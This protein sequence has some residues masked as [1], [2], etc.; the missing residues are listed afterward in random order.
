M[1]KF[2]QILSIIQLKTL[3][4]ENRN[5]V[6]VTKSGDLYSYNFET[7]TADKLTVA[8]AS[9]KLDL[10]LDVI[11]EIVK[12]GG[13][14]IVPEPVAEEVKPVAVLEPE[15]VEVEPEPEPVEPEEPI[16]NLLRELTI[17]HE[18]LANEYEQ[19]RIELEEIKKTLL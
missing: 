7:N 2:K 8:Q 16:T 9:D 5:N 10:H 12:S 1:A 18:D 3:C 17:A 6:G 14:Y 11:A 15:P 4:E 13:T 19:L